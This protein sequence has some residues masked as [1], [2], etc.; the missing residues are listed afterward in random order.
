LDFSFFN[1]H[2]SQVWSFDGVAEF[3]HITF[4]ALEFFALRFNQIFL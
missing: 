3:F 2:G 1:A 4:R